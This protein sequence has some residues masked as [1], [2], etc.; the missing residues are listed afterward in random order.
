[1]FLLLTVLIIFQI[2]GTYFMIPPCMR[3]REA[4]YYQAPGML[5]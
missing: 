3:F 4:H 1:M 5:P 2:Q